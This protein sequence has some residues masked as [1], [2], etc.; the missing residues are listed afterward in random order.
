MN[1]NKKKKRVK[2]NILEILVKS[3]IIFKIKKKA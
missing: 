1:L 2:K 3:S